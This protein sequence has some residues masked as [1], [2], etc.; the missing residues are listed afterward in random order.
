M[1]NLTSLLTI[2][3][4]FMAYQEWKSFKFF[5]SIC[6]TKRLWAQSGKRDCALTIQPTLEGKKRKF[7]LLRARICSIVILALFSTRHR[8]QCDFF[9]TYK[10]QCFLQCTSATET[11]G[12]CNRAQGIPNNLS[13][14]SQGQKK[15]K[16]RN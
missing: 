9:V 5:C 2:N 3:L 16:R 15:K 11:V 1:L 6:H 10:S 12:G 4:A 7:V 8:F 13:P 14:Q